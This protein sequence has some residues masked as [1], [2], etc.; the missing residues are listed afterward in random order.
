MGGL[1]PDHRFAGRAAEQRFLGD[2]LLDAAAGVPHAIVIHGEAGIGKTRL[3]D[4]L[5]Q[6]AQA[7]G[8][9]TIVGRCYEGETNLAYGPFVEGLRSALRL[10]SRDAWLQNIPARWLMVTRPL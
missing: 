4:E 3:A 8:A 10:P 1:R 2:V 7:G 9:T 6:H 5:L